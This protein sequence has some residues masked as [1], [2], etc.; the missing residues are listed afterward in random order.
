MGCNPDGVNRLSIDE[1]LSLW[2]TK[3]ITIAGMRN[4]PFITNNIDQCSSGEY[5]GVGRWGLFLKDNALIMGIPDVTS[6]H[7]DINTYQ[8]NSSIGRNIL[9]LD[10]S[11]LVSVPGSVNITG[12]AGIGMVQNASNKLSV[13]G[14]IALWGTKGITI[15]GSRN[16]PYITSGV[17]LATSGEYN[18]VG[19]WGIFMKDNALIM[20]MPDA[21]NNH[22][23]FN[24][25]QVNSSI[26]RTIMRLDQSGTVSVNGVVDINGYLTRQMVT[27][28][29]N[30]L[31]IAM[32]SIDAEG[33]I[34]NGTGNFTCTKNAVSQ[35]Y[36]IAINNYPYSDNGYITIITPNTHVPCFTWYQASP[37]IQ[38]ALEIQIWTIAL[39]LGTPAPTSVPFTFIVY[40]P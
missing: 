6:N 27:G 1:G 33:N 5:T 12:S 18:G 31:P 37:V 23:D 29:S 25:Y 30:M 24:T 17:D 10:Q 20:G 35:L 7:I 3:G 9:R 2:G 38:F 16:K 11:G 32:G 15:T 22:I 36:R 21:V 40:K 8:A 28:S 13:D 34:I 26:G 4:K 14:G 19:R 39:P